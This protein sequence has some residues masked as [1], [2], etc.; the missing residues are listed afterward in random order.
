MVKGCTYA[1][2]AAYSAV[3]RQSS[4]GL[5]DEPLGPGRTGRVAASTPACLS[6]SL[7]P[8]QPAVEPINST[9]SWDEQ[10]IW[11]LEAGFLLSIPTP[12]ISLV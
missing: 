11:A 2:E 3:S 5:P 7:L 4:S 6:R 10:G 1:F 12:P 9:P 8:R